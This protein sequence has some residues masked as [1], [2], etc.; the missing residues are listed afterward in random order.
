MVQRYAVAVEYNGRSFSGWQS[1]REEEVLTVQEALES[2][3]SNVANHAVKVNC[4]GRTDAGVHASHQI[5]HFESTSLRTPYQW[6]RGTNANLPKTVRLRW[7][8]PVATDFHA[9]FSATARRYQ[10]HIYNDPVAPA[11]FSG[12][13]TWQSLPLDDQLMHSTAQCMLGEHDFSSF[14]AAGCQSKS[15]QRR[16]HSLTVFRRDR[17]V[18]IDVKA[19]AFLQHMVRNIAGVLM[20]VGTGKEQASWVETVLQ[21]QDRKQGGVTA[22]PD[23]LYFVGVDYPEKHEL[24]SLQSLLSV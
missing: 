11:I 23:G 2:A 18:I 13:Y 6:L 5:A 10:Y 9:R 16:I 3:L 15:P 1:Q 8:S 4:A 14:R 17:L 19:N 22:D 24:P 20:A 7:V 12:L 21:A